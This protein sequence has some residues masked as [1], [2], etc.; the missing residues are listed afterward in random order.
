MW[1]YCLGARK[2]RVPRRFV[3]TYNYNRGGKWSSPVD[4]GLEYALQDGR[5]QG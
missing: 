4:V 1:S 3:V 2:P 5:M